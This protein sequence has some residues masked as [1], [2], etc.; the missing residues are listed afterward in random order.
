LILP[1]TKE[2]QIGS[3][4]PKKR[5]TLSFERGLIFHDNNN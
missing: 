2:A 5:Q 4:E 3:K 1:P